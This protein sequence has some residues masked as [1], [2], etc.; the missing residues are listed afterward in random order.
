[1]T[2]M[3]ENVTKFNHKLKLF[4][5]KSFFHSKII[6][7]NIYLYSHAA[8]KRIHNRNHGIVSKLNDR[9]K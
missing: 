6:Y 1:M 5:C 2:K 8:V 9:I 7:V 3:N 4:F